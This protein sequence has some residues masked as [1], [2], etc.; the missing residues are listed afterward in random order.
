M[1]DFLVVP[2]LEEGEVKRGGNPGPGVETESHRWGFH[3]QITQN[4]PWLIPVER[5]LNPLG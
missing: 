3:S 1:I 2:V 5:C 4:Q